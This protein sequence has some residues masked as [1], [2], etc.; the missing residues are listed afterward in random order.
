[1]CADSH[2]TTIGGVGAIGWGIGRGETKNILATQAR[3]QKKPLSMRITFD[4]RLAPGVSAKDMILGLL[5][6]IGVRAGIGY[7][8]EF[9]GEAVRALAIESRLTLCNMAIEFSADCGFVVPDESTFSYLAGRE[10]AP[11]GEDWDLALAYWRRLV[12]D[13]GARFDR[14]LTVDAS[15]LAP[16]IS[17]GTSPSQ[18]MAIDGRIPNP[19]MIGDAADRERAAQALDYVRLT[20]GTPIAGTPIEAAYIGSCTNARLTDLREAARLLRNGRV[21]ETVTAICVPGS[22]RVKAE[23]EAEGLDKVF[24][25]AGFEWHES[26]C[27]LCGDNGGDRIAGRRVVSTTNRNHEGRQG[28]GAITHLA[29]PATVAASALAGRIAD[30]RQSA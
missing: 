20:P 14:E 1:M 28:R 4:G 30:P 24:L 16:Q 26:G 23:A 25:A 9:A 3:I 18:V 8:V 12:T 6:R 21:P 17:W 7:A 15:E 27:G 11:K 2:T 5:G 19:S 29:S 13:P 10:F 22:S